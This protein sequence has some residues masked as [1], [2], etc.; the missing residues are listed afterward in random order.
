MS[1]VTDDN[2]D[3]RVLASTTPV[4]VMFWQPKCAFCEMLLPALALVARNLP[5]VNFIVINAS[6]NPKT[7]ER[8]ALTDF[9]AVLLFRNGEVV[10]RKLGASTS[11][12][13]TSWIRGVLN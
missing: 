13:V 11:D 5:F 10:G 12:S 6:A 1:K 9:P 8:Y 4:A 2:F 3:D 7:K